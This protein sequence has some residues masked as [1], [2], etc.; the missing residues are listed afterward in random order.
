MKGYLRK[1]VIDAVELRVSIIL[2]LSC[3][4]SGFMLI[5]YMNGS[6]AESHFTAD[7]ATERYRSG[8]E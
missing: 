7:C 8:D 3:D 4:F 6:P 1:S 5:T 2:C